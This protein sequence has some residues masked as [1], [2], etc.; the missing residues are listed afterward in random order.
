MYEQGYLSKEEYQTAKEAPLGLQIKRTESD[1]V[2]SW[3]ADMVIEDV[4]G[5]LC[6]QYHMIRSAASSLLYSGGL[7]IF[8][9]I[10]PAIQHKIE[11]YYEQQIQT[12]TNKK[13]E[14]AQSALIVLDVHT[15]DILGVAGG[16]GTKKGNRVQNF[17]TQ[18]LRPPGSAIKPIS[19]YAP[20]L[21]RGL[22][23][24][25]SVFDDVPV[26]FGS[27][28][29]HAWP[30]NAN[31]GYRGLT[32]VAYAVAESTNTVSVKI[33]EKIGVENAFYE[34]RDRF[35][36]QNLYAGQDKTDCD[37]AA[38]AL[39]QLNYGV[40]L[41]ELAN[42][43]STF[44]DAGVYR[45]SRSYYRVL[46]MDGNVLLTNPD[47][48]EVVMSSGNAAIMTKLLEEVVDRGTASS[49][50]LKQKMECAGKTGT[51]NQ[52]GDRWFVGYTPDLICGV[53]SGFE[54]PEPMTGKNV[55]LK[56]WDDVM[57]EIV[58]SGK[59][60]KHFDL[61]SSL[62]RISYCKDSGKL[63]C[64]ACGYDPRGDRT[65]E[66]WFVRGTEPH[67]LCDCHV[68]CDYDTQNGGVSHGDCPEEF[69]K[70]I[71]LIKVERSF[72]IEV[73]V[74]DAQYVYRGDPRSMQPNPKQNEAYFAK[75]CK[76][77]CGTSNVAK[78][79]NRSC[80]G[81][82]ALPNDWETEWRRRYFDTS[83]SA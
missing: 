54:Y 17:A 53:W 64:E 37:V 59:W 23:T 44:A 55:C 82:H 32:D 83:D 13:G 15:G 75:H 26:N 61:P 31:N 76:G 58:G 70:K 41:R 73:I 40:T 34:A 38:L 3:Y 11:N 45:Q 2:N 60:K 6:E 21:E 56:I 25:S 66:G 72:P 33:L 78:P 14:H 46:D 74:K 7:Q 47:G 71:A 80:V 50:T 39:G 12:P 68:L 19:V 63:P 30:K 16:V 9:A 10:D 24:W 49:I 79:F 36:L 77:F 35:H 20:A 1:R 62:I 29:N 48:G 18:T 51:T 42:A 5:D 22:I 43:Y 65:A 28:E 8:A 67:E 57:G 27:H 4:I 81:N 69:C 52:N